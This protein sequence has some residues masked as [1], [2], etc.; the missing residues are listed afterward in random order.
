M[1]RARSGKRYTNVIVST[2]SNF[3]RPT[4]VASVQHYCPEMLG[5]AALA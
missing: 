1:T 2:A 4:L 3:G 5:K